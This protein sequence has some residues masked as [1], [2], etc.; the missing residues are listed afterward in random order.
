MVLVR[1]LVAD[2]PVVEVDARLDA[3]PT[4][5]L[6]G[7]GPHYLSVVPTQLRRAL[8]DPT[9][10]AVLRRFDAVLLGG[11]AAERTLLE[12]AADAGVRVVTTYGMSETCGGCVYDGVPLDGVAVTADE[13]GR[14]DIVGPTLF[15][16][17]RLDPVATADTLIGGRLRTRDR[18]EVRGDGRVTVLGRLDDVVISG[19]L[20][21]DLAAVERA[22]RAWADETVAGAEAAVVGVP[23]PEWGTEV[24]AVV[25][26]G[27]Q[28]S[29]LRAALT[30]RLPVYALPRRL[31]VRD[32]LPRTS[33]GKIDRRQLV[34]DL[35]EPPHE[36]PED[37]T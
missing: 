21:V 15:T 23:H 26:S 2:R 30:D 28:L 5:D 24:V 10:T 1:S 6:T 20:N 27:Q 35:I 17:Y 13:N 25:T 8:G 7:D 36:R 9:R 33:G 34:A 29:D 16:G 37:P 31:V 19:G 11:A 18:G 32:A 3:L 14:L 22:V 4:I 12:T